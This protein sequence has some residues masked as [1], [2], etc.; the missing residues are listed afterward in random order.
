MENTDAC[1]GAEPKV[2]EW[3]MTYLNANEE[4]E[5]KQSAIRKPDISTK[6][7]YHAFV[8]NRIKVLPQTLLGYIKLKYLKVPPAAIYGVTLDVAN[9]Q[10]NYNPATS[11]NSIFNDQDTQ[12]LVDLMLFY[13]GIEVRETPLLE[14]VGLRRQLN[15][16]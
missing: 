11:V 1:G 12:N 10:E 14:W 9:D 2:D 3:D 7:V 16:V 4:R 13:K 6:C 8:N 5:T 15:A